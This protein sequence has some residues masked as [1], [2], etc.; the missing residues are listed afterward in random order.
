MRERSTNLSVRIIHIAGNDRML[1]ADH[2]TGGFEA[3]IQAVGAVVALGSRSRVRVHV[4]GVVRTSLQAGLA[5]N[6]DVPVEFDDSVRSLVHRSDGANPNAG[7]ILTVIAPR[8]LKMPGDVGERPRFD[9]LDP[10]PIDPE[11]DAV[12]ALACG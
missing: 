11:R 2:D 3:N 7:R 10:G 4:N 6:A 12:F 8:D 1:G 5:P 9:A